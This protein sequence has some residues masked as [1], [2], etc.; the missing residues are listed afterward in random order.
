[1]LFSAHDVALAASVAHRVLLLREGRT[2]AEGEPQ[3]ALT[4]QA[5]EATYERKGRLE[6]F[7]ES[8]V[9]VFE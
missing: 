3:A 8:L 1:V 5:L 4:P 2:V 9:A 6:R 7:G